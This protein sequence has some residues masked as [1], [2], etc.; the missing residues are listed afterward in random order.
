MV[1]NERF[2]EEYESEVRSVVE[3][4]STH[5]VQRY[6]ENPVEARAANSALSHFV[7]VMFLD[8]LRLQALLFTKNV[9]LIACYM[10]R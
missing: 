8:L 1:R 7:K 2:N 9:L 10:I 3:L 6:K 4:V 5:I